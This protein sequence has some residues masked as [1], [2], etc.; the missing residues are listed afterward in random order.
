MP[1]VEGDSSPE[2]PTDGEEPSSIKHRQSV[3]TCPHCLGLTQH[4]WGV[5]QFHA[6]ADTSPV[7]AFDAATCIGCNKISIWTY[8]SGTRLFTPSK[9]LW[10]PTSLAPLGDAGL[11]GLSGEVYAEAASV[12][13]ASPRAAAALLR[14]C[15]ELLLK[16]LDIGKKN[17]NLSS[18]IGAARKERGIPE[19]I[20]EACDVLR[21]S[22]NGAVHAG[23]IDGDDSHETALA[24]FGLVNLISHRLVTEP[25]QVGEMYARLPESVRENIDKR[26]GKEIPVTVDPGESD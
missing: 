25:K 23:Q 26:D 22:G 6:H 10:P 13:D 17:D 14:L 5:L 11:A 19:T 12:L 7:N 9:K 3:T 2:S 15:L 20:K 21:I 16:D 18:R 4:I 8:T 1:K 24:L